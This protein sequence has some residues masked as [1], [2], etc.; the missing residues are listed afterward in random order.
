MRSGVDLVFGHGPELGQLSTPEKRNEITAIPE[1]KLLAAL[2]LE[3]ATVPIDAM[4]T[5]HDRCSHHQG[6]R[7]S[8]RTGNMSNTTR[9]TV[10]WKPGCAG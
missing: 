1:T 2:N 5:Q 3:G 8:V 9:G 4:G 6:G 7:G 10:G